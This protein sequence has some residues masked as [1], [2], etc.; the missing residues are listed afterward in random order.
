ME[1]TEQT[2]LEQK[3]REI[4]DLKGELVIHNAFMDAAKTVMFRMAREYGVEKDLNTILGYKEMVEFRDFW[5]KYKRN[6]I[7]AAVI[8]RISQTSFRGGFEVVQGVDED[9]TEFEKAWK[10]LQMEHD[11]LDV[12]ERADVLSLLGRYGGILLGLS[13]VTDPSVMRRPVSGMKVE[14]MYTKVLSEE[15]MVISQVDRNPASPRYSLPEIYKVRI[16]AADANQPTLSGGEN[17]A[18]IELD[19]HHTR[20]I[21][22]AYHRLE[23]D[24][25]GTPALESIYNR[26]ADIEKLVGGAAEMFWRGARPG[27]QGVL[28]K[29]ANISDEDRKKIQEQAEKFEKD[30]QRFFVQ[31]GM[32]I[33]ALA[34]QVEDPTGHFNMLVECVCAARGIPKRVLLGSER[35]ELASSQDRSNWFET[36][37]ARRVREPEKR[38]IR[39]TIDR[40]VDIGMLPNPENGEYDV[41]WADLASSSE[42]EVVEIA[43]LISKALANYM[44]SGASDVVPVEVFMKRLGFTEQEIKEIENRYEEMLRKEEEMLEQTPEPGAEDL[45]PDDGSG[46]PPQGE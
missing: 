25:F 15:S 9:E 20:I 28:D 16:P 7:A 36:V 23:N 39:P 18:F 38:M 6:D 19:V 8:N 32:E 46:N 21:H 43:E 3:E 42:K 44:N 5:D 4:A 10:Q 14:L 11:L 12:F 24:V 26:L 34:P 27:Y 2:A 30:L 1:Q 17:T 13:D 41:A 45:P 37:D 31:K 33:K 40:F 35:G 29:E 22:I